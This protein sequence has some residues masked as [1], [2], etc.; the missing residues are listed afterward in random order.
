[1]AVGRIAYYPYYSWAETV[2]R[3]R[4]ER[5]DLG[6]VMNRLNELEENLVSKWKLDSSELA[7]AAKF[8]DEDGKLGV[9]SLG[10]DEVANTLRMALITQRACEGGGR[11]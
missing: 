5:R 6:E 7:S 9:S 3:P 10:P 1:M 8:V 2:V 11:V 4:I